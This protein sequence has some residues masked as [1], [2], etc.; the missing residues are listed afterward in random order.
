M[1]A[2]ACTPYSNLEVDSGVMPREC[3]E[4]AW[5]RLSNGPRADAPSVL[6]RTVGANPE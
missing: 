3:D 1:R 4:G 2:A 6:S 5:S